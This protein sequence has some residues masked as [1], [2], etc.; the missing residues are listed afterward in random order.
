M[1]AAGAGVG[2]VNAL[3]IERFKLA[4]FFVVTLGMMSVASGASYVIS[5]G[6]TVTGFPP[7]I[8]ALGSDEVFGIPAAAITVLGLA[9][10]TGVLTHVV[11]W[12]RWIYAVGGNREAASRVGIPVRRVAM[13]AFVFSG[14]AAGLAGILTAGL[15]DAGQPAGGF[16]SQL[17]AISAVIIGGA[18]LTGGRG[19]VF[20]TLVGALILGTIHNGL[21]LLGVDTNWEPIVLGV[22]LVLAVSLDTLR[23]QLETR[24]QLAAARR[25]GDLPATGEPA[26]GAADAV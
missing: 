13:S 19:T 6:A 7:L 5:K 15:T 18:A 8:V 14:L 12:G 20:G 2:F 10:L 25:H 9:L 1:L 16:T 11:R 26:I 23:E 4:N 21:N 24:L 3:I 17:D 22:V